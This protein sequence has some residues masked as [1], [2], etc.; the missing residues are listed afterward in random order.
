[1]QPV[2][3]E[4]LSQLMDGEWQDIEPSQCVKG[5]CQDEHL[6][7]TWARYHLI[8]DAMKNEPVEANTDLAARIQASIQDEITYSNV[9]AIGGPSPTEQPRQEAVQATPVK[10]PIQHWRLGLSGA[11]LAALRRSGNGCGSECLARCTGEFTY[12]SNRCRFRWRCK[13]SSQFGG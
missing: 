13:P 6:R 12:R 3:R 8:R 1:M 2:D 10:Q 11:A 7:A 4:T 9:S 5:I